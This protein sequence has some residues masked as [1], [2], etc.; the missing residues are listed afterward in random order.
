V[1]YFFSSTLVAYEE[2][3]V[4][5]T[6]PVGLVAADWF[7]EFY[8]AYVDES[9]A[10]ANPENPKYCWDAGFVYPHIVTDM[11]IANNIFDSSQLSYAGWINDGSSLSKN[12]QAYFGDD[13]VGS[14]QTMSA[15][16]NKTRDGYWLPGCL[17]H[18]GNLCM[19][20]PTV[21]Q[22]YL[23][24]NIVADWFFNRNQLPHRLVDACWSKGGH[25]CNSVCPRA[26]G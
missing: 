6:T 17:D 7:V 26:C 8:D 12:Y 22:G 19:W 3:V 2:W 21:V 13:V 9:C 14:I 23:F 25:P 11:L 16:P 1:C 4:G 24:R 5:L 10:Q 18:T 20:S 15:F